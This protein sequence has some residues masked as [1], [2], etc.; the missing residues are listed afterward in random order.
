MKGKITSKKLN[1]SI[2]WFDIINTNEKNLKFIVEK[3]VNYVYLTFYLRS[4][5]IYSQFKQMLKNKAKRLISDGWSLGESKMSHTNK[6]IFIYAI[7]NEG[8]SCVELQFKFS[9][10]D[11]IL[12]DIKGKTEII[13]QTLDLFKKNIKELKISMDIKYS[14][15][16]DVTISEKDLEEVLEDLS[17]EKI[18]NIKGKYR[19]FEVVNKHNIT[20]QI[21]TQKYGKY[22]SLDISICVENMII[23]NNNFDEEFTFSPFY[24]I[25]EYSKLH[26]N[27]LKKL[28]KEYIYSQQIFY[29]MLEKAI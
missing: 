13:S 28:D 19:K 14:L 21:L 10:G 18:F 24:F 26:Y 11:K 1:D 16:K 17:F 9:I 6:D 29:S 4:E 8:V 12:E 25:I 15:S 22:I 7:A 5:K 2:K 20:D 27:F 3:D 23:E